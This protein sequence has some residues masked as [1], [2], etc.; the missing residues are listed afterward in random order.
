VVDFERGHFDAMASFYRIGG[1][2]LGGKARGLAFIAS[3]LNQFPLERHFPGIR[4]AVPS[5][6]AIA[7]EVFDRFME[8]NALTDLALQ[9][10][11]EVEVTRAFESASFP[12][13]IQEDLR[14]FLARCDF[15]LAVRSSSLLEDSQYQ[16]F[17]GIYQTFMLPNG[18]PSLDVRL[19]EL[20]S[21][22]KRVYASTYSTRAKRF[23]EA[24]QYR[25]EEEKMAVILQ[26]VVGSRG[27]TTS[28]PLRRRGA[29]MESPPSLSAS[30]RRSSTEAEPFD[31][32]PGIPGTSF[33]GPPSRRAS[34]V[35]SRSS[36]PSIWRAPRERSAS[37]LSRSPRR[38]ERSPRS[39]PRTRG[40]TTPSTTE[41]RD[42]ECA[43]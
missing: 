36:T 33:R 8:E 13:E 22:V 37:I 30:E 35:P 7:T 26:R 1:G 43:R 21:A 34:K 2:S 4:I 6:V 25:L 41:F 16:P 12:E 17:A 20:L 15:P 29:R 18:N 32:A 5:S 31:S 38:T 42:R 39:L 14:A 11:S 24:T 28:I 10:E 9:S 23:L 27:P 19:Q 40:R 3:L